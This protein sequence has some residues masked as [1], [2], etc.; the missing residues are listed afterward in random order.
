LAFEVLL[1]PFG[2]KLPVCAGFIEG[3]AAAFASPGRVDPAKPSNAEFEKLTPVD[4]APRKS[5]KRPP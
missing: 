5:P 3:A 4:P 1:S 2:F